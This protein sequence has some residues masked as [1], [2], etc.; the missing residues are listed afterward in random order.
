M[1]HTAVSAAQASMKNVSANK[2][3]QDESLSW[4]VLFAYIPQKGHRIIER[5]PVCVE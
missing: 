2:I 5:I 3:A 4:A 1:V